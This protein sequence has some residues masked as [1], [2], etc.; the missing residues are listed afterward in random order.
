M[1]SP[2]VQKKKKEEKERRKR[3]HVDLP[4]DK[5]DGLTFMQPSSHIPTGED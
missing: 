1:N 3:G 4:P 2:V 5:T